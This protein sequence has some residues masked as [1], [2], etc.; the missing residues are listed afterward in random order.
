MPTARPSHPPG[1]TARLA[2]APALAL[3]AVAAVACSGGDGAGSFCEQAGALAERMAGIDDPTTGE[4]AAAVAQMRETEPP[5]GI[6]DDWRTITGYYEALADP[7]GGTPSPTD[8]ATR[9]AGDA[10]DR[11]LAEECG[12]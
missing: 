6:A 5:E 8:A 9:E 11:Y 2:R 12:I 1:R 3:A 10:V 4:Y 7:A